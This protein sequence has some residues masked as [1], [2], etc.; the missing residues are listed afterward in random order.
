MGTALNERHVRQIR[1]FVPRVVL[2]FDADDGGD[3][4]VDRALELFSSHDMELA[5]ASLPAGLDPCDLLVRDGPEPFRRVL[6]SATDVL[7]YKLT[8]MV[9]RE[10]T[11]TVEGSRR[12][13]DAVLRVIALAP[14]MP[15]EAGT[16]KRQLMMTRIARRLVL[17]EETTW[18]RLD[19]LRREQRGAGRHAAA[20]ESAPN[21]TAAPAALEERQLLEFL[22]AEPALVGRARAALPAE[23]IAHP[24]LRRLLD[25]LYALDATGR[26]ATL[27]EL[28]GGLDSLPLVNK[29][30]E[31]QMRG[32]DQPNREQCLLDLL[33]HFRR[34]RDKSFKQQ[35]H[36]QLQATSDPRAALELLRQLQNRSVDP[37]PDATSRGDEAGLDPLS[38][39]A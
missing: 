32:L 4:G 18:A 22:L 6:E 10:D 7:E 30:F 5:V 28:R 21:R 9:T 16:V 37:G 36:S 35:L 19:E 27:D 12:V 20:E 25:G 29:A 39:S 3:T 8:Q 17:R 11:T 13:L 34:R 26:P 33:A 24:G 38:P 14:G 1:R 15:G 23:E 2:V 31:L